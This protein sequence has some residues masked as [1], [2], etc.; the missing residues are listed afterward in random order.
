MSLR[1]SIR[2]VS[3]NLH[4][5]ECNSSKTNLVNTQSNV[6]DLELVKKFTFSFTF[7]SRYDIINLSN[8]YIGESK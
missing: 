2:T 7:D 6:C 5:R 8:T 4:R 3:F 1:H